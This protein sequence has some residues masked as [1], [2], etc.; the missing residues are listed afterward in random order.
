M[1]RASWAQTYRDAS[2]SHQEAPVFPGGSDRI[3]R[4]S[5]IGRLDWMSG[6]R[7]ILTDLRP[8]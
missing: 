2:F 1:G 5:M 4:D 3:K 7:G 6:Q 8:A